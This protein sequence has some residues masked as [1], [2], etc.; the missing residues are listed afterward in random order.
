MRS[1]SVCFAVSGFWKG[2]GTRPIPPHHAVPHWRESGAKA[3]KNAFSF[4]LFRMQLFLDWAWSLTDLCLTLELPVSSFVFL[5]DE[6]LGL[7]GPPSCWC[8]CRQFMY[9]YFYLLSY[10]LH[11]HKFLCK[12]INLKTRQNPACGSQKRALSPCGTY[13][14]YRSC[15]EWPGRSKAVLSHPL[16]L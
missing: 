3:S 2:M 8:H 1:C 14:Q 15:G 13:A 12:H 16:I 4:P 10:N 5:G 7:P 9:I 11:K 6:V